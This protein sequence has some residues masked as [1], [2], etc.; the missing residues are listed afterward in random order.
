[1]SKFKESGAKGKKHKYKTGLIPAQALEG[2][3]SSRGIIRNFGSCQFLRAC[4]ADAW[5]GGLTA[6]LPRGVG[7]LALGLGLSNFVPPSPPPCISYTKVS[8]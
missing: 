7:V 8:N 6:S 5:P 4:W 2:R 3:A 1:M